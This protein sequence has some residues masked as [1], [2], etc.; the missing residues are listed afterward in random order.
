M[1]L[2]KS[3]RT[4][5]ARRPL[6]ARERPVLIT[7]VSE[8]VDQIPRLEVRAVLVASAEVDVDT[9]VR[10]E[11]LTSEIDVSV[12]GCAIL[13][14]GGACERYVHRGWRAC[15]QAHQQT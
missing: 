8:R 13:R 2:I 15:G 6:L 9:I 4:D 11:S 14:A 5:L 1:L 7:D 10:T 3:L 12:S